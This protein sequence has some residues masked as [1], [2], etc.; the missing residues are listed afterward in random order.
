MKY[1]VQQNVDHL[2]LQRNSIDDADDA[3]RKHILR[4]QATA[5]FER[6]VS[7]EFDSGPF[8]L[9][10]DDLRPH[11]VI[12][13]PKTLE[14]VALIDLE[15]TYAASYQFLF[16]PPLWLILENPATWTSYGIASYKKRLE[17]FIKSLADE[18]DMLKRQGYFEVSTEQRM[19]TLMCHSMDDGKFWFGSLLRESYNFDGDVLWPNVEHF[20]QSQGLNIHKILNEIDDRDME[21]LV[22]RK[23]EDLRQYK[24]ELKLLENE[25]RN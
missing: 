16:S 22:E 21:A 23:V 20:L 2:H 19:S 10:C 8:K 11:N 6:F 9:V 15:W 1:L 7:K 5:V 3:R 18:E 24:A 4:Q 12:V 13:D 17:L 25:E 14:I